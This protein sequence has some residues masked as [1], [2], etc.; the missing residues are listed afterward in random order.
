[1]KRISIS[2]LLFAGLVLIILG[3]QQIF[4]QT[5]P[6]GVGTTDGTSSLKLWLKADAI[7]GVTTNNTPVTTW[8]DASGSNNNAISSGT[9]RPTY[10]TNILN[11]FPVVRFDGSTPPNDDYMT[12]TYSPSGQLTMF[13]V[14][15]PRTIDGSARIIINNHKTTTSGG[16]NYFIYTAGTG[17]ERHTG[18]QTGLGSPPWPDGANIISD[19][20]EH[21][22]NVGRIGAFIVNNAGTLT[23]LFANGTSIATAAFGS[24]AAGQ[25]VLT[26][27]RNGDNGLNQFHGDIAEVII[28]NAVLNDAER[29]LVENYLSAKYAITLTVNDYYSSTTFFRNVAGIGQRSTFRSLVGHSLGMILSSAGGAFVDDNGDFMIAGHA[30]TS[31]ATSTSDLSTTGSEV[32]SRWSRIWFVD[33]TDASS[34]GGTVTVGFDYSEGGMSGT[35]SGLSK[36][37]LLYRIGTTGD[38]TSH[39]AGASSISGDQVLF[40]MNANLIDDGYFTLGIRGPSLTVPINGITGASVLPT[41]TWGSVPGAVSYTLYVDDASDFSTPLYAINQVLL[42]TRTFTALIA[43]FPL[44]NSQLY[45]WKVVAIDNNSVEYPSITYHFTTAPG[46]S[47]SQNSPS[48]GQSIQSTTVNFGWSLGHSATGLTFKVE[49]KIMSSAPTAESHWSSAS[50][51]TVTG[52][53]NSSYSKTISGLTLGK[54]YYWR[55]LIQRSTSPFDYVHYPAPGVYSTFTTEGGTTVTLTPNWPIGGQVVYTNSPRLDWTISGYT[56]G[57]TY[58]LDYGKATLDGSADVTGL[59][60]LY[61]QLTNLEPGATYNWA[62]IANYSGNYTSWTTSTTFVVNGPGTLEVPTP[63]Y[64]R[65]GA[66]I[67]SNT[68]R[69]DWTLTTSGTGLQY[70]IRYSTS[71]SVNAGVLNGSDAAS[72]PTDANFATF[73]SV[74]YITSPTLTPGA[75]YYWQVRSYSSIVDGFYPVDPAAEAFSVW[76]APTSFVNSGPGTLVDVVPNYPINVT[77]Y[78]TNPMLTWYL[79]SPSNGLYFEIS[80]T[81]NGTD[82][83]NTAEVGTTTLDRFYYQLLSLPAG[84]TIKWKIR[85]KRVSTLNPSTAGTWSD[86][87]SFVIAGGTTASYAVANWPIGGTTVYTNRP[88]LSWYLEGSTLGITGYTVKYHQVAPATYNWYSYVTGGPNAT[89]GTYAIGSPTT[90]NKQIDQDLTYGATYYWGVYASNVSADPINSLGQG[91]FTIVGGPGSTTVVLSYP[92]NASIVQSTTVPF[93]WY[94]SGSTAGIVSY[95]LMYSIS[96]VFAGSPPI[97][98]TVT[99]ITSTSR[100]ITGLTSGATYYWKVKAVYADASET[101]FSTTFSFTIQQG[102]PI[103]V[104]PWIGG[105]HNVAIGTTSPTFSWILPVPPASGLKYELEYSTSAS[106]LNSTK[107]ENIPNQYAAVS[108]LSSNTKYYWRVRSKATDGTYSYYSNLG[109]FDV[110]LPTGVEDPNTIPDEFSL[111]QNYPNPFN[112]STKISF[113]LPEAARVTIRVFNTLGQLVVTVASNELLNAGSYERTFDASGLPTGIYIYQ[114]NSDKF[115]S[116]KKMLMIK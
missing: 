43:N 64:P 44:T 21:T 102:S 3:A 90:F 88:T 37:V 55:V 89:G 22:V 114:L 70:Q 94:I 29:I 63:N 52:N 84:A 101:A 16:F 23:S 26:I 56:S 48:S 27:G 68:P 7:T 5:G 12:T 69:L 73:P 93:S 33:K 61:Y 47:V 72:Y 31:N 59:T 34:D 82:P 35:P 100:T 36:F 113:D 98:V 103:I 108:G 67:Y 80:Y 79:S 53:S 77:V 51:T 111:K 115:N 110:G 19:V 81:T 91:H 6:G 58:E 1:M 46:F 105:P 112:P 57:L 86:I 8:S 71:S 99:G 76:S 9:N 97:T 41:M 95:T 92:Y 54:T 20:G 38:F 45:Y 87:V 106:F 39:T 75:T 49:Y 18:L 28:Y 50:S 13:V 74:Q 42:L 78:T 10:L 11:T 2:F 62:V 96:D 15:V 60:N 25:S 107:I 85:S 14:Y 4:S 30:S 40:S 17:N 104:Q 66:T 65:D 32:I 24:I 116:Y 83:D 109:K